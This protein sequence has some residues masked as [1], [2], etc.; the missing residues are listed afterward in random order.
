MDYRAKIIEI[1]KLV[2]SKR[3]LKW[4]YKF[5]VEWAKYDK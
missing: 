3:I 1:V 2:K 5:T 4:I